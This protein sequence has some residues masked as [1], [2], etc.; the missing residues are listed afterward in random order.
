MNICTGLMRRHFSEKKSKLDNRGLCLLREI[1]KHLDTWW[2]C[3]IYIGLTAWMPKRFPVSHMIESCCCSI[4]DLNIWEQNSQGELDSKRPEAS[5]QSERKWHLGL[6]GPLEPVKRSER[7]GYWPV[8]F[9]ET[10]KAPLQQSPHNTGI[11]LEFAGQWPWS[12]LKAWRV[13]HFYVI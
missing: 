13:Q 5:Q 1:C 7:K 12:L 8:D 3:V 10:G 11:I 2:F 9:P 4:S 6:H